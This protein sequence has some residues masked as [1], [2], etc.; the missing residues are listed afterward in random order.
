MQVSSQCVSGCVCPN[1]L[2]SNGSGGC[3]K[4]KDCPCPHEGKYYNP[5]EQITV[6]C[7]EW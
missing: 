2:L 7:N 5:G 1:G 6:D 3:V 4:E